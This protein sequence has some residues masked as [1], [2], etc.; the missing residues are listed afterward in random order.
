M[1]QRNGTD[2]DAGN[3]MQM[4]LKLGYKAKVYND[5]TVDQIKKLLSAGKTHHSFPPSQQSCDQGKHEL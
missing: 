5:Q 2:V 1:N 4:F 3:A